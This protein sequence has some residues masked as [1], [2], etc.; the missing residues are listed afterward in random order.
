[1]AYSS[2]YIS[3]KNLNEIESFADKLFEELGIDIAF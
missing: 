2:N 3:K 1:M